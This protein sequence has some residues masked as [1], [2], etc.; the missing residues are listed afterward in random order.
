MKILSIPV[1]FL[2]LFSAGC[3][4][5]YYVPDV[6]NV[7]LFK[8][9]D[10]SRVSILIGGGDESSCL[11]FQGAY[12]L[13]GEIGIM[14][15]YMS[16]NGGDKNLHNWAKGHY[17]D[18]AVGYYKSLEHNFIFEFYGGFGA[19]SEYHE[20]N[21]DQS[22]SSAELSFNKLFLQPSLGFTSDLIDIAVSSRIN[23][24]SF[25]NIQNNILINSPGYEEV[26]SLGARNYFF[27]EPAITV[28]TGWKNVKL[29][30]Q[31]S[32]ATYRFISDID[33]F[34]DVH[35]SLGLTLAFGG[36]YKLKVPK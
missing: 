13:T 11:E 24:L 28:R 21:Y 8:E 10:E 25:N 18:G 33:Y 23:Y 34:E 1:L 30:F 7:P 17:F 31:G 26:V 22:V 27:L 4:H 16:A 5:Y 19:G 3:T 2:T 15:G 35:L 36:R 12:A 29:Q 14:A 9:K 20:Y 6:Q 32:M